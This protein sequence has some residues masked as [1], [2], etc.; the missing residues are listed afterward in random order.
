MVPGRYRPLTG[1]R[2]SNSPSFPLDSS[3]FWI[4]FSRTSMATANASSA[5]SCNLGGIMTL[6]SPMNSS[7]PGLGQ[8]MLGGGRTET[9]GHG[10]RWARSGWWRR[11]A[12]PPLLPLMV[13]WNTRRSYSAGSSAPHTNAARSPADDSWTR[14][15]PS[16]TWTVGS[17]GSGLRQPPTPQPRF[18]PLLY[19]R[20]SLQLHPLAGEP[21]R[22]TVDAFYWSAVAFYSV[23]IGPFSPTGSGRGLPDLSDS[24][25][26]KNEVKPIRVQ[27]NKTLNHDFARTI[28]LNIE[29]FMNTWILQ[30]IKTDSH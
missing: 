25:Q 2:P 10:R 20:Q 17:S 7:G 3:R 15:C 4:W 28:T 12:L 9:H 8:S 24:F 19:R 21:V 16:R 30:Q 29:W 5:S 22:H 23:R 11:V 14:I 6:S 18:S 26:P 27:K 1:C 13:T